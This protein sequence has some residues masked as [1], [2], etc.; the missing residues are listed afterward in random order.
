MSTNNNIYLITGATGFIGS[1]LVKD[2]AEKGKNIKCL[3]R[4]SSPKAAVQFLSGL[5]VELVTGDLTDQKSLEEG[6]KGVSTIFHLGGGGRI[7]TPEDLCFRI[8]PARSTLFG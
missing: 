1:H 3:I 7:D 6:M 2:L 8:N 4:N 5:G